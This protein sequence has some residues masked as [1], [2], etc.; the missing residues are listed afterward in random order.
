MHAVSAW[1]EATPLS[2]LIQRAIWLI[3]LLQIIHILSVAAIFSSVVMVM[4]R[5]A[6]PGRSHDQTLPETVDRFRPW[7]WG[8]LV[9]LAASGI[10][11]I[12]SEPKR[13]LDGNPAFQV[14]LVMIAVAVAAALVFDA[15]LKNRA[16]IWEKMLGSL[17]L[18]R[19]LAVAAI[20]LF[21]AIIVAGRWIAYMG[22]E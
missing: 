3:E 13:A 12:V 15:S 7:F 11:L 4:R 8:A 14:K 2:Q 21:C 5:A 18:R 10:V 22:V 20:V 17:T 6:G 16:G 9:A 1:L 19:S